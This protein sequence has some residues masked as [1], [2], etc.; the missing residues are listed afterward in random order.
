MEVE[1]TKYHAALQRI[2]RLKC[3]FN[4]G[5]NKTHIYVV[6]TFNDGII[7]NTRI[8]FSDNDDITNLISFEEKAKI[9]QAVVSHYKNDV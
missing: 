6:E 1:S 4:Y 8:Q 5:G 9:M 3:N 2:T 7:K